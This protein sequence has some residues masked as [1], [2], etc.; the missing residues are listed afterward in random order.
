MAVERL[1]QSRIQ[2]REIP[3]SPIYKLL[4]LDES[5]DFVKNAHEQGK[6]VILL[7][8]TWDLT[9]PGHVQH[10][11]EAKKH[12]DLILLKLASAEYASKYKGPDRPIEKFRDMVVSEFENVDAVY[13]EEKAIPPDNL[14][15]NARVL[16]QL[17]PDKIAL[18]IEDEH[19]F[20]K[21][22]AIDYANRH[23]GAHI[24]PVVMVLPYIVSTTA[25]VNK[26]K[27]A[28]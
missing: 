24:E 20:Q 17:N 4:S 5:T 23:L 26:I 2:F 28:K 10:I 16:V 3:V 25:I 18:E 14:A 7:E 11:R 13:V 22:R 6:S 19:F 9:H 1:V 12:A 27:E 15:E 8:G 21:I